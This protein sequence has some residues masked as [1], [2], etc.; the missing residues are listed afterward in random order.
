MEPVSLGDIAAVVAALAFVVLVIVTAKPLRRL[1]DVFER[2]ATSVDTLTNETIPTL[3][4]A[5]RAAKSANLQL[6]RL[7]TVTAAAARSAEDLSAATTLVTS[8]VTAPFL[9]VRRGADKFRRK[10]TESS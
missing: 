3:E 4:E 5:A 2:L 6:E 8:T 9:A 7:D 1:A 10:S